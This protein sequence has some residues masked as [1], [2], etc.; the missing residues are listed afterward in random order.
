MAESLI[1]CIGMDGDGSRVQRTLL[2]ELV[3]KGKARGEKSEGI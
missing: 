2:R 1:E 3:V